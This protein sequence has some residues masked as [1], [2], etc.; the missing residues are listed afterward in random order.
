MIADT[1]YKVFYDTYG[2]TLK[3]NNKS[4]NYFPVPIIT[5]KGKQ[6]LEYIGTNKIL[7]I[8]NEI[9][10][11][12]TY[13]Y[14]DISEVIIRDDSMTLITDEYTKIIVS[15]RLL[16]KQLDVLYSFQKTIDHIKNINDYVYID[17]S[18][19]NKIIVKEKI[20]G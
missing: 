13:L 4:I 7:N 10:L 8:M 18:V 17:L 5:Y 15:E 14:N 9:F 19:K 11:N 20:H 1:N 16:T 6:H 12:N 3:V 2:K